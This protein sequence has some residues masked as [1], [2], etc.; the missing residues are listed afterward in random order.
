MYFS[1][2]NIC[3]SCTIH[4]LLS[5]LFNEYWDTNNNNIY[6]QD[7]KVYI[8]MYIIP[9]HFYF[10]RYRLNE[11]NNGSHEKISACLLV[12]VCTCTYFN[13]VGSKHTQHNKSFSLCFN[14]INV[15]YNIVLYSGRRNIDWMYISLSDW[16]QRSKY[17]CNNSMSLLFSI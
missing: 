2:R 16:F 10:T 14:I 15:L 12:Y 7:N 17:I 1:M 8:Y 13:V 9:F 3:I 11:G 6:D 5:I 4:L